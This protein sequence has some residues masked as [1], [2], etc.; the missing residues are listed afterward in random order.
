MRTFFAYQIVRH[1]PVALGLLSVF[2]ITAA[3]LLIGASYLAF[4]DPVFVVP[5]AIGVFALYAGLR[6]FCGRQS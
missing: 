5:G 1:S 6:P 3:A 4:P 2:N